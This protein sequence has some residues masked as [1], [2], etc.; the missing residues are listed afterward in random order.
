MEVLK[1]GLTRAAA[2]SPF[3]SSASFQM[4]DLKYSICPG[5]ANTPSLQEQKHTFIRQTLIPVVPTVRWQECD[6]VWKTLWAPG[7]QECS[8]AQNGHWES[9]L[10]EVEGQQYMGINS[11]ESLLA[12]KIQTVPCIRRR[13]NPCNWAT[14]LGKLRL[15]F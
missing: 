5:C 11:R 15:A 6:S 14:M 8:Q 10:A 9:W 4:G 13:R 1:A 7:S 12:S 3:Q 2:T